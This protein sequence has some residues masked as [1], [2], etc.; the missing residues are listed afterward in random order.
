MSLV[1]PGSN[2]GAHQV[3]PS[4]PEA[5]DD[6]HPSSTPTRTMPEE[7]EAGRNMSDGDNATPGLPGLPGPPGAG[8]DNPWLTRN[9]RRPSPVAAP[10]ERSGSP[11]PEGV[12]KAGRQ[13]GNHSDGVTVADLIAKLH[14]DSRGREPDVEPPAPPTEII[15][16]VSDDTDV[17]DDT[18]VFPLVSV[19]PSELPDLAVVHQPG[20]DPRA[21]G[22]RYSQTHAA[23]GPQQDGAGR[24]RGRR[25]DR[26]AGAGDDRCGLAMA[27]VEEQ[28]AQKGFRAG[29]DVARHRRS[30]GTTR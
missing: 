28:H 30:N 7:P 9:P 21:E 11:E 23:P 27:I 15:A 24:P 22:G 6:A 2:G 10:W 4:E 8:G 29:P 14:G 20:P 18:D 16:A 17:T 5:A 13:T 3:L 1:E 26:G 12:E 19:Q 25:P